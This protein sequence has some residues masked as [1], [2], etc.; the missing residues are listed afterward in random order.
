MALGDPPVHGNPVGSDGTFSI[1]A[2]PAGDP[3]HTLTVR[4]R[5]TTRRLEMTIDPGDGSPATTLQL[6]RDSWTMIITEVE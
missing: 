3:D 1:A 6:N 2:Q 4:V 5:P